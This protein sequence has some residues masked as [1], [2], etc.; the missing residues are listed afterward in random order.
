MTNFLNAWVYSFSWFQACAALTDHAVNLAIALSTSSG[1]V[2]WQ[3][4]Y[5]QAWTGGTSCCFTLHRV[6]LVSG[7]V[8][9]PR[10]VSNTPR[11]TLAH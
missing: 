5:H 3:K 9:N 7:Q 10:H 1:Q 4:G 2:S 6:L 8:I 11:H